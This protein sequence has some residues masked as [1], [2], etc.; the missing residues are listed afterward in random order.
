MTVS[1]VPIGQDSTI[2][3]IA[4]D[5]TG[6]QA[7]LGTFT[8]GIVDANGD[9]VVAPGTAVTDNSDGTYE[10]TLAAQS[11]PA[12]LIV[13]WTEAGGDAFTTYLDVQDSFLFNEAQLR[14]F[15]DAAIGDTSQ[16]SDDAIAKMHQ[17]VVE[18]MEAFTSRSWIRRY[19]R[20]VLP[21]NGQR[22]LDLS[23]GF[24]RTATGL[25]LMR[26][27][28]RRDIISIIRANDGADVTTSNIVIHDGVLERTD[29]AW[30]KAT[31][32]SPLNVT[33]EY[34][35]GQPYPVD[36][37]D[38]IAMLIAR[39]WLVSSRIPANNSSF[40]DALG[41]FTFA[42]ESRLPFEAY[43]WLRN[44]KTGGFFA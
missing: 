28:A 26:P 12:F 10:Y 23:R 36:G 13:T 38:R 8:I 5:S 25:T 30:A 17:R 40:N 27:G 9:E 1:T 42:D 33:V 31:S 35:Y 21:G 14:V 24:D 11:A 22:V 3:F 15:D 6:T 32:D 29:A 2:E 18:Y 37:A 41:T 34:E 4:Y 16:Y 39:Q 20:T 44:H 43:S 19:N 7:D